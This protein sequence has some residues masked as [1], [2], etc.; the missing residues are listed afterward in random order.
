MQTKLNLKLGFE[1]A[2]SWE[3]YQAIANVVYTALGGK[4]ESKVVAVETK[5]DA[6]KSFASLFGANSVL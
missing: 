6:T 2:K 4:D 1:K 5:D 3:M